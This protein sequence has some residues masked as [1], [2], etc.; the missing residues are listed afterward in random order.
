MDDGGVLP[1]PTALQFARVSRHFPAT[2]KHRL[3]RKRLRAKVVGVAEC[4][5]D[6]T[7]G[8]NDVGSDLVVSSRLHR[9]LR[10]DDPTFNPV[11]GDVVRV[12]DDEEAPLQARVIRREEDRVWVQIELPVPAPPLA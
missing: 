8:P 3:V 9:G 2:E 7:Y 12:G 6:L 4:P 5:Y 1:E 11:P 10:A